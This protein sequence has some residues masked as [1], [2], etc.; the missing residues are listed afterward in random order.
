MKLDGKDGVVNH[1]LMDV[2]AR[3]RTQGTLDSYIQRLSVLVQLLLDLFQ[4]TDI[5][6]VKVMHLRSCV[7]YLMD[8][9]A[10]SVKGRRFVEGSMDVSTVR[11]YVRVWK[12][13]FN[14]CFQEELTDTNVVARLRSPQS[15]KKVV[16]AFTIEHIEKMLATC[17]VNTDMGFGDYVI[18]LLFLDTG[19][20][21]SELSGLNVDDVNDNF[22]KV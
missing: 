4:V 9:G 10:G 8:H 16:P 1:F 17:D 3:N 5:E 12:A 7:Q 14:W 2:R 19:M 20:R 18:L 6:Q 15:V 21:L 11:G 13:F 22:V